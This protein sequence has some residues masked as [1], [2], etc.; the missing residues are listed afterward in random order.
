MVERT[1]APRTVVEPAAELRHRLAKWKVKELRELASKFSVDLRGRRRKGDVVAAIATSPRASEILTVIHA[2]EP[3][4]VRVRPVPDLDDSSVDPAILSAKNADL[5]FGRAEDL[6]DQAR[7]RYEER[8]FEGSLTLV[9]QAGLIAQTT[10]DAFARAV[11]AY[12]ILS[13]QRLIEDCGQAGRDVEE[14]AKLLRRTKRAFRNG[15]LDRDLLSKLEHVARGLYSEEVR[16]AREEVYRV[17]DVVSGVANLGANVAA[18]EEVLSRARDALRGND[19]FQC[20]E[21]VRLAEQLATEVR[22]KRLAEIE[23]SIPA[24][25]TILEEARNVGADVEEGERLLEQARVAL[26]EDEHVLAGELVKRAERAAMQS[27]QQQIEKAM[28]L[29]RR[30]VDKAQA[31]IRTVEP[32]LHEAA[33]FGIDVTE[34]RTLLRQASEVLGEGDYVN[35]T[36]YARNAEAAIRRLQPRVN[37]ERRRRGIVKPTAGVCGSCGSRR[38]EFHDDGWGECLDCRQMF[39]WRQALGP[40]ERFRSVLRR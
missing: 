21:S 18:A 13:C 30:Q 35:G 25:A 14:A 37:E 39:R 28:E 27:Q 15:S 3:I 26:A 19:P 9:K 5:D 33:S 1:E 4:A 36:V 23:A 24:T 2:P 8:N 11:T 22:T 17:Q 12:A 32:L 7:M 34:A 16:R 10:M 31:I 6:L 20:T 38:L 40:W 29:R